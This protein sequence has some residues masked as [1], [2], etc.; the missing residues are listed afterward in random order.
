LFEEKLAQ[1]FTVG[2][3]S[4]GGDEQKTLEAGRKRFET[5]F[6]CKTGLIHLRF[7]MSYL[8]I[9]CVEDVQRLDICFTY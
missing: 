9:R 7:E 2:C 3:R 8:T 6:F 4:L 1:T 5:K